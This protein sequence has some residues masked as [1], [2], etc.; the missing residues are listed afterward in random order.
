[1]R[2][3]IRLTAGDSV[4]LSLFP[5]SAVAALRSWPRTDD[6][7]SVQEHAVAAGRNIGGT[8]ASVSACPAAAPSEDL[9]HHL[10]RCVAGTRYAD[11][12][13]EATDAAK[14]SIL[15]T[16]AVIL[17]ASGQEPAVRG[18]IEMVRENGGRPESSVLAFGGKAPA[19]MA[20]FANGAMAHCLDY[21]DQTVWGQHASSSIVP[22]VLAI[23]ERRGGV[24]GQDL[25]AAVAAGQDLFARLRCNLGWR[26]D[27]NLSS[28][29]GVFAAT[30]ASG[31]V[32]GFPCDRMVA[33]LGIASMQSSGIMEMVAGTGSD[34]RGLYAGFSAK[35]AVVATLLAEKGIGGIERLFQG[36]HGV[37]DCYFRGQYDIAGILKDLG[38]DYRGAFTLYKAWPSVGTSHSHIH[39]TIQLVTQHDLDADDIVDIRVHVGDYHALMC[40]PLDVRRAPTTLVDARFSLPFL[41]AVAAVRRGMGIGDFT[42]AALKDRRILA[43]ARKVVPLR[44]PALDWKLELPPGRVEI[45]TQDGRRFERTGTAIPGSLEAPLS[46]DDIARKFRDCAAVA[47]AP[48][49][50]ERISAVVRMARDLERL[51]DATALLRGL[52]G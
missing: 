48:P 7:M 6:A 35:G 29:L 42:E 46:W 52:A 34:L 17:A 26:K 32:L 28:V 5:G 3:P 30:A 13:G 4:R 31:R 47:V 19:E 21:D 51:D 36:Q 24:S 2:P 45:T 9:V 8:G 23:A 37:F 40:E 14:K 50:T 20:A 11:L 38:R 44:D 43:A 41:V 49:P 10:A 39:A 1:M 18:A 33:A 16:L 27:W 12:P 22:A 25:I 15:D